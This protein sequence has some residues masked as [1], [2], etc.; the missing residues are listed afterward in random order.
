VGSA[1]ASHASKTNK[2]A[3]NTKIHTSRYT[4]SKT[5]GDENSIEPKLE[6]GSSKKK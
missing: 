1:V 2:I 5:N 3:I 4:H 6:S